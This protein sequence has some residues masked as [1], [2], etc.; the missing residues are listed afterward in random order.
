MLLWLLIALG[1][2][3]SSP[4][5]ALA[6]GYTLGLVSEHPKDVILLNIILIILIIF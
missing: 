4:V 3:F 1:E 6:D 5:L 2:F